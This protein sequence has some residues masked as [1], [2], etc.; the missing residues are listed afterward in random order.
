MNKKAGNKGRPPKVYRIERDQATGTLIIHV[1]TKWP[2]GPS[3][4][5]LA[6]CNLHSP[7]GFEI[8]YGGSG[9]ADTAASILADYFGED[10]RWV[11]RTWRG[12]SNERPSI[13]VLLHQDFKRDV[14]AGIQLEPGEVHMLEESSII[15]WLA[16]KHRAYLKT[17]EAPRAERG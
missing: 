1:G 15:A 16:E 12:R 14:I 13:A 9:P 5:L 17:P 4:R 11:E 2:A 8:G 10:A 3:W 6:H 7:T